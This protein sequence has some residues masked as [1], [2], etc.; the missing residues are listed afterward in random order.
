MI[1]NFDSKDT[2]YDIVSINNSTDE[3]IFTIKPRFLETF[4]Q[5]NDIFLFMLNRHQTML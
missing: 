2:M 5:S 4:L 1:K 3:S